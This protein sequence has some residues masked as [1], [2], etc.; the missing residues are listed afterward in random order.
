MIRR[1]QKAISSLA[2]GCRPAAASAIGTDHRWRAARMP[3]VENPG[4]ARAVQA[5]TERRHSSSAIDN[6]ALVRRGSR[7]DLR[8]NERAARSPCFAGRFVPANPLPRRRR[9]LDDRDVRARAGSARK[10]GRDRAV[11]ALAETLD[12]RRPID[13]AQRAVSP[14]QRKIQSRAP[15]RARRACSTRPSPRHWKSAT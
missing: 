11:A 5:A 15:E 1:D 13:G 6:S 12:R 3:D 2:A 9:I 7:V 8:G 4:H 10:D 14:S